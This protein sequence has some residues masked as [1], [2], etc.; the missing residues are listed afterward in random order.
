VAWYSALLACA[1]PL[2]AHAQGFQLNEI[3]TCAVGRGMATTALTCN[4]PSVIYWNP[5]A[6]T[7]L[8]GWSAYLGIAAI[9]VGGEFTA[10]TTGRIDKGD[11]PIEWPPH[12][13]V[14]YAPTSGKWAAGLGVYV[15][16]GLTSQWKADFP[17]RFSARKASLAT[18]YIQ[19]NF[20]YQFAPGWSIG[21]GPVI[22]HS[23]VE[24]RQSLDLAT[25]VTPQ[26]LTFGQLGI[27]AQTEFASLLVKGSATAVGV[28]VGIH[29]QLAANWQVG[30]RYLSRLSFDYEG[31]AN[32]TPVSTGITLAAGNPFG[33]PAGTPLNE[34]LAPQFAAAGPLSPQKVAT[35]IKHPAQF[36]VGLG[37]TGFTSTVLSADFEWTEF[38]SFDRLP[39]N[40]KGNAQELSRELIEDFNN[41]WSI[42]AGVEHAFASGIKGRAGFT[43]VA[44]PAPDVTVTPLLPDMD[45][46]NYSLGI[47]LPLSPRYT[48]DAAYLRVDASGRRGRIVERT[49]ESQTAAQLN[50]GFYSLNA[51]VFS[52]SLRANF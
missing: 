44:T 38:S 29:G 23:T 49:S 19:P 16:Y 31:D 27:P 17:G 24:L 2:A 15:P 42:R 8:P 34:V 5:A 40:F 14:S 1:A 43:Y 32:F 13:F 18:L 35:R 4:D 50:S 30:A 26:G 9:K 46:R 7:T 22:G 20:S 48:L 47:G 28:N 6:A 45:R 25:V 11:V 39:V 10:D 37:Y 33:A 51:N 12:L 3:G 52:V 36:Q 21:G 41:S